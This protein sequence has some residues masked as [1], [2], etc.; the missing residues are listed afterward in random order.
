MVV[1]NWQGG[2]F[3]IPRVCFYV[4]HFFFQDCLC[5]CDTHLA[6]EIQIDV[7]A[8]PTFSSN[9]CE[10]MVLLGTKD[11]NIRHPSALS[12]DPTMEGPHCVLWRPVAPNFTDSIEQ[13]LWS[14]H[15]QCVFDWW[16]TL[17]IL[18]I[19]TFKNF[20]LFCI[21]IHQRTCTFKSVSI[22]QL[23]N[24]VRRGSPLMGTKR[25]KS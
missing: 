14:T 21:Y 5:A 1:P 9:L 19:C 20:Y 6:L 15:T 11:K 25:N 4:I 12:H 17:C 8:F 3:F 2:S 10:Q 16:I 24:Q 18:S 13:T 7:M 23:A 22:L